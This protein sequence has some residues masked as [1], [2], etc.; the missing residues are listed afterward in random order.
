MKP[1]NLEKKQLNQSWHQSK[2]HLDWKITKF[3]PMKLSY[4]LMK[5]S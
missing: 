4:G 3:N 1:M 5:S 2:T